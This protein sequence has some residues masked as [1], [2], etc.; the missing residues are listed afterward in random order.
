MATLGNIVH[1]VVSSPIG[2][3]IATALQAPGGLTGITGFGGG[4]LP[5]GVSNADTFKSFLGGQNWEG[6]GTGRGASFDPISG[7]S[8]YQYFAPSTPGGIGGYVANGQVLTYPTEDTQNFFH[9][10]GN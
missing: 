8:H 9:T 4:P 3:H 5:A 7:G 1:A 10:A 6:P 2:Q